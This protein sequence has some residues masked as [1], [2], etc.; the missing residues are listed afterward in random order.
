MPCELVELS[1][2]NMIGYYDTE[3]AALQDVV[4]AVAPYGD[5]AVST[6]ALGYDTPSGAGGVIAQGAALIARALA[7]FPNGSPQENEAKSY[8]AGTSVG[9]Q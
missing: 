9:A 8:H 1:T 5:D 4:D 7:A 3:R 6:L 2:G